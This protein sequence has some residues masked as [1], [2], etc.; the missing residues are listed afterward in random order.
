MFKKLASLFWSLLQYCKEKAKEVKDSQDTLASKMLTG[1][2]RIPSVNIRRWGFPDG[3]SGKEPTCQ[4][5]R[6]KRCGFD[7]RM[8]RSPGGGHGTHPSVLAWRIPLTEEP[9]GLQSI[10]SQ[11]VRHD[12]SDLTCNTCIYREV[13][14][15]IRQSE[16]ALVMLQRTNFNLH[17]VLTVCD[18]ESAWWGH[19]LC[20]CVISSEKRELTQYPLC[21]LWFYSPCLEK[22]ERELDMKTLSPSW[23]YRRY[24]CTTCPVVALFSVLVCC[25]FFLL[26]V[27]LSWNLLNDDGHLSV[28]MQW[29]L[30]ARS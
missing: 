17:L 15:A 29:L 9:G 28:F 13:E 4:C 8:G 10:R 16:W 3:A 12:W 11:R 21:W 27:C 23:K 26:F 1:N 6:H 25:W 14:P 24:R 30:E 20:L 7:L 2:H 18:P 19:C 5:K 22:R